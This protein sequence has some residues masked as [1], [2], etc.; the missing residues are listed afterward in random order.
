LPHC[1]KCAGYDDSYN[2]FTFRLN[3]M[4]DA[5]IR[6]VSSPMMQA[7]GTRGLFPGAA[8]G[9]KCKCGE[10]VRTKAQSRLTR[11]K[12]HLT[13]PPSQLTSP[14]S[15]LTS[16]QSQ[17]TSPQSK[18]T[19]SQSQLTS[20]QSQLTSPQFQLTSLNPRLPPLS[21]S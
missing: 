8:T 10:G 4:A 16:P 1:H 6:T 3:K 5:L 11:G 20:P 17:L 2:Q 14:Q 13:S 12:S 7:G 21:P 19:S 18:F 15:Q 9:V